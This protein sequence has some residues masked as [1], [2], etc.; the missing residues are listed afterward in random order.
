MNNAHITI[1]N[2]TRANLRDFSSHFAAVAGGEPLPEEIADL[3]SVE[4]IAYSESD[5]RVVV[6]FADD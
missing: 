1:V 6:G 2:N 3:F 4:V 5:V